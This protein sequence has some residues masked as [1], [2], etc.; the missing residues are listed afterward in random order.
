MKTVE[1]RTILEHENLLITFSHQ[2]TARTTPGLGKP[3]A[4]LGVVTAGTGRRRL[5]RKD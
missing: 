3:A 1:S 4:S 2:Q 5:H